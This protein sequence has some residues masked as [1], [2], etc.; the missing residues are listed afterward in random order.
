MT[1]SLLAAPGAALVGQRRPRVRSV[2]FFLSTSGPEALDLLRSTGQEPDPWQCDAVSD[3][4]A[5]GDDGRWASRR[6]CMITPRQNGKGGVIEPIELFGLFVLHETILH[7]AHL[8][9]TARDAFMRLLALIEGTPDLARRIKRVNM[10]HGKE[11][12]EL[13]APP[14]RPRGGGVYFHAR[15]KGGGRGKSPQRVILDEAFALTREQMAALIPALSAQEDPQVNMFS[16]PPPVGEPC[17]VL[18]QAR[19]QVLA[20]IKAGV[21]AEMTW[22]E[23]GVERGTDVT[24]PE[25]WAA[26]NPAY[27]IRITERTC[28][29][30]LD[31]LG[32]AE[33]GVERCGMWPEMGD[34]QWLVI[35]EADWATAADPCTER[36]GRP[37]FSVDMSPDRSWSAIS[38]AF[39]RPDGLRQV[40]VIDHRAGTGWVLTRAAELRAHDPCVWVIDRA[41]PAGSLIPAFEEA[42]FEIV[43]MSA[44]DVTAGSGMLYDGIAGDLPEDPEEPSPRTVRHSGEEQVAKAV[45]AAEKRPPRGTWQFDRARPGA[46]LLLGL[47]GALWGLATHGHLAAAAAEPWA[48]YA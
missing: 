41:S 47:T 27:G 45:A 39:V 10:A 30:E 25:S 43:R 23:W 2:P 44:P 8:F 26:A 17:Q 22:L 34:A 20:A 35:P 46:Y 21:P 19:A 36:E 42:G 5:E 38:V 33:F 6:T 12:I 40:Q 15:T 1:R 18:M 29:D 48:F 24:V 3:I 28:R 7:S 16:T 4:L 31:A 9:D 14:N 11:G 13:L 32:L 37:A